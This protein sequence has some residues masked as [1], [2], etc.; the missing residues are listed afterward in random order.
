M[1]KLFIKEKRDSS[2]Y[3]S[4]AIQQGYCEPKFHF[5]TE[6]NEEELKKLEILL[7]IE[8]SNI[9]RISSNFPEIYRKDKELLNTLLNKIK[10]LSEKE[11][12]K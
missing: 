3:S 11:S 9:D 2:G 8:A 6:F 4:L 10:I 12:E 1:L 7:Y 5:I